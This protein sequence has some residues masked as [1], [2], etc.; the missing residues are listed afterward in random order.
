MVSFV[1]LILGC[2]DN[3]KVA[4]IF[5][6]D[7]NNEIDDQH[8]LAYLFYNSDTFDIKGITVNATVNGGSIE[9]HYE[10]A[11]RIM[12]LCGWYAKTPLISGANKNFKT[13]EKKNYFHGF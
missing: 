5:D 13:I 1:L 12:Q 9:E 4:L 6:T 11:K 8:A 7:A 10:E 3:E 2:S